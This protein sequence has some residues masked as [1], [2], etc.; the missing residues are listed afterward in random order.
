MKTSDLAYEVPEDLIAQTP[1]EPRDAAR[2]LV[3]DRASSALEH[4]TFRDIIDY[5][6]PG[7]VLVPNETRVLRA[8]LRAMKVPSGGRLEIL[9][10]RP[11]DE[12]TWEALVGGSGVRA[13]SRLRVVPANERA[14]ADATAEVVAVLANGGRL[15]RFDRPIAAELDRLGDVPLPPYIHQPLADAERYQT[16]FAR[17]MGSAAAPTAGLHFTPEL[18]QAVRDRGVE[19]AF[20][21]LQVGWDTFHPIQEE[22]VE[23]HHIHTEF[24]HVSGK[25]AAQINRARDAGGR[26]IAVGTTAVRALETAALSRRDGRVSPFKGN[27]NLFI[28]P[29]F[30]FR[31][32][33][34]MITNFHLPRSTLLA[35]VSAFAGRERI[36]HAYQVAVAERYRFY[37]FGDAMLIR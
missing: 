36:L 19:F 1:I 15:L 21:E 12:V 13:G 33:D 5:L 18:L 26:V 3:V 27:S 25:A 17:V 24:C 7:D 9:L 20:I 4:R 23:Q 29:G 32:V 28:T 11:V 8:R 16:V 37:S 34:A 10:L 22:Q 30:E 31:V 35:L 6:Q 14:V 2:L